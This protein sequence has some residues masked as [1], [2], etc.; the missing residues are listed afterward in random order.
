MKSLILVV[1]FLFTVSQIRAQ[2]R[3]PC[4]DACITLYDPVCGETL[5]KGKVLRCEFGNS[6]FMAASA[7]THRISK[8]ATTIKN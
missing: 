6:C 8:F 5:I 2:T 7:C 1:S 4:R 3:P